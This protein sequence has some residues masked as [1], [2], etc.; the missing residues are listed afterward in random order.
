MEKGKA[1]WGVIDILGRVVRKD[2]TNDM[3]VE[4]KA[5]GSEKTNA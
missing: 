5:K 4:Q 3:T 1:G 2:L